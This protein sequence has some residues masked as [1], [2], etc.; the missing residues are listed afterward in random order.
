MHDGRVL[1]GTWRKAGAAAPLQLRQPSGAMLVP[2]GRTYVAL[3]PTDGGAV[4]VR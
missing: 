2:P 3:V 1:R 4:T